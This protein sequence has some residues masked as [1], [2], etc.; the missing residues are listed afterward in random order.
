[1]N[2]IKVVD[3]NIFYQISCRNSAIK[4]IKEKDTQLKSVC[5]I[6]KDKVDY[7]DNSR[8]KNHG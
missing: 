4:T 7:A 8:I 5:T 1:M 3:K 6:S 2:E